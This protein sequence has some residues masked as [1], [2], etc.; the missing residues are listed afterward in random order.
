MMGRG[1][2]RQS[3]QKHAKDMK[4]NQKPDTVLPNYALK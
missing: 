4:I 3:E 2:P 1:F